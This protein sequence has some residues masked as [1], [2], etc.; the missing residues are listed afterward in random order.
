MAD[1]TINANTGETAGRE[2]LVALLNTGTSDS[3][4]WSPVGSHVNESAAEYD[5]GNETERDIL[6]NVFTS[7]KKP[8]ITQVFDPWS[9]TGGDA[10]QLKIIQLAVVE[11]N[12]QAL[13]NMDMLIAHYY[14]KNG[15]AVGSFAE[16]YSACSIDLTSIGGEGGGPLAMPISV[17]YGG[18]RTV[19]TVNKDENGIVTF[20]PEVTV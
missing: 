3:P 6:G 2:T 16:R 18:T 9:L 19:G 20:T 11:Q 12:A 17:T 15:E 14:T 1:V 4:V 8:I 7:K 10:A 5:W 13:S